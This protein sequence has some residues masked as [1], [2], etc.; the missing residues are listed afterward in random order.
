MPDMPGTQGPVHPFRRLF[1]RQFD[2]GVAF[3]VVVI[4][5]YAVWGRDIM[6]IAIQRHS[7]AAWIPALALWPLA[8]AALLRLK[9]NTPGKWLFR[10]QVQP[11]NG[12]PLGFGSVLNRSI[13]ALLYGQ[14]FS[15]PLIGWYAGIQSYID[16]TQ[17]GA[18][19]WDRGKFSVTGGPFGWS[20]G[21]FA[22]V[23]GTALLI[24]GVVVATGLLG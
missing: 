2:N 14:A 6:A 20:R 10:I 23:A 3:V 24:V 22:V 19:R 15:L 18:T 5:G 1:A 4:C 21:L 12:G 13:N 8:E 7:L 16:L 17:R 11:V 9:L